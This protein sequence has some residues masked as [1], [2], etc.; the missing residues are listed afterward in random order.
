[1]TEFED[2]VITNSRPMVPMGTRNYLVAEMLPVS[3]A[4]G[5]EVGELQN[6]V[7]KIIRDGESGD[8]TQEFILEAGDVLHYLT[9]LVLNYGFTMEYIQER[10]IEKLDSRRAKYAL[11]DKAIHEKPVQTI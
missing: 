6:V 5:G 4:L 3:N 1:M 7:K 9:R 11:I 10:N 2:Y 8:L